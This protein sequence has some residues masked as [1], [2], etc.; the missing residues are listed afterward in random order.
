MIDNSK[1]VNE[2]S[3]TLALDMVKK[4][5]LRAKSIHKENFHNG[6][7]AYGVILEEFNELWEEIK[8]NPNKER[9]SL[10]RQQQEAKQT[11]AMLIRF[12]IELTF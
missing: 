2:S 3:L 8:I 12:M 4:E 1:E 11:A 9:Y 7:E 10:F 5:V 6:H